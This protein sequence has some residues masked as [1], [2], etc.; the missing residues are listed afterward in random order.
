[1]Y[2][3]MLFAKI[4][5]LFLFSVEKGLVCLCITFRT[6]EAESAMTKPKNQIAKRINV[7]VNG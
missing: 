4:I 2:I 7:V 5:H 6:W 3:Y 1:M